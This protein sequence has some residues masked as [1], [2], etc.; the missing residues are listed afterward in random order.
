MWKVLL[1]AQTRQDTRKRT[2]TVILPKLFDTNDLFGFFDS[3]NNW[4]DG[5]VPRLLRKGAT[6]DDGAQRVFVF[7]GRMESHW[8]DYVSSLVGPERQ[9]VLLNHEKLLLSNLTKVIFETADLQTASPGLVS[10]CGVM[11]L[12]RK[13]DLRGNII[14]SW[15]RTRSHELFDLRSKEEL[16]KIIERYVAPSF[17]AVTRVSERTCE[18]ILALRLTSMLSGILTSKSVVSQADKLEQAF[19]FALIWTCAAELPSSGNARVDFSGWFRKSFDDVKIPSAGTVFDYYFD[20]YSGRFKPWRDSQHFVEPSAHLNPRLLFLPSNESASCLYFGSIMM[21]Q[22]HNV[23]FY[24]PR[25]AGK[26]T[27][28]SKLLGQEAHSKF[29]VRKL[30]AAKELA[31]RVLT[32][33]RSTSSGDSELSLFVDDLE[34]A[35]ESIAEL[36]RLAMGHKE[37][38]DY[39]THENAQIPHTSFIC[40]SENTATEDSRLMPLLCPFEY[41]PASSSKIAMINT[42]T[43]SFLEKNGFAGDSQVLLKTLARASVSVMDLLRSRILAAPASQ[44]YDFDVRAALRLARSFQLCTPAAC[45]EPLKQVLFWLHEVNRTF[46]D[47]LMKED[48]PVLYKVLEE[49]AKREF[50]QFY[51]SR[52]LPSAEAE[53]E[54]VVFSH[55]A[56]TA[57]SI[58]DPS[59]PTY[60]KVED[61]SRTTQMLRELISQSPKDVAIVDSSTLH[62]A[63]VARLLA[64]GCRGLC[65]IGPGGAGKSLLTQLAARTF[66]YR[67]ES[68]KYRE[69]Y[70]AADFRADWESLSLLAGI[71]RE[72]VFL[73]I[74]EQDVADDKVFD[75]SLKI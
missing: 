67:L 17:A 70:S 12:N 24:G 23:L 36:L 30:S 53:V 42:V 7:D 66:G 52:F 73:L 2:S 16:F 35:S 18:P 44:H 6:Q 19:A 55:F 5:V 8:C 45:D 43:T 60:E 54:P 29:I 37:I 63:K 69:H 31:A 38:V 39:E 14:G 59:S 32:Q 13:I 74:S 72:G 71:H 68:L 56:D 64:L 50:S 48:R 20:L 28:V 57:G 40:C 62:I 22:H 3:S 4:R 58:I 26:S 49:V 51:I 15:L 61:V 33:E 34:L 21:T 9:L 11:V 47:G 27:L 65:V 10:H 25:G 75:K 41:S 1:S 46:A